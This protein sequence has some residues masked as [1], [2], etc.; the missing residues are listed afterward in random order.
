MEDAYAKLAETYYRWGERWD[1]DNRLE[2]AVGVIDRAQAAGV[3][4][5][6][7]Y[8]YASLALRELRRFDEAI[9]AGQAAISI[10]PT[11]RLAFSRL[12]WTAYLAG[13]YDLSAAVS[14]QAIDLDPSD[15][16]EHF[17]LGIALAAIGDVEGAG[18]A[19][20]AGLVT[21][22]LPEN[23]SAA[24]SASQRGPGRPAHN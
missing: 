8:H 10:D 22:D 6:A 14:Q 17:N 23:V 16:R 1:L 15:P 7:V 19:Y 21:A 13:D 4:Q 20:E 18:A 11:Y 2:E 5:A 9:A 12:G 24:G 3:E